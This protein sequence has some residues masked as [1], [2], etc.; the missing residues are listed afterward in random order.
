MRG[1]V[2]RYCSLACRAAVTGSA[3]LSSR[4]PR[5]RRLSSLVCSAGEMLMPAGSAWLAMVD[6]WIGARSGSSVHVPCVASLLLQGVE[7]GGGRLRVVA[8]VRSDHVQQRRLPVLAHRDRT[9]DVEV[10]AAFPPVVQ[11]EA[12]PTPAPFHLCSRGERRGRGRG[13]T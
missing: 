4:E 7:E 1:Y 10:G 2:F 11:V 6:S 5:S 12:P 13:A 3:R 9:A 8:V